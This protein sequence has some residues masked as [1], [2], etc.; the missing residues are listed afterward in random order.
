VAQ[1]VAQ[2][3]RPSREQVD[4]IVRGFQKSVVDILVR[5]VVMAA[6]SHQVDRVVLAG[7]VAAND[8]LRRHAAEVCATKDLQLFAPPKKRC[9]DNAS[10]IALAGLLALQAGERSAMDLAPRANWPL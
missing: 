8:G 10:M 3:G 5:K 9:T 7:G 1:R 2:M 4:A 6:R